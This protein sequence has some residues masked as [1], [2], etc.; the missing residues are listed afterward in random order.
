VGSLIFCLPPTVAVVLVS[1][2]VGGVVGVSIGIYIE[3]PFVWGGRDVWGTILSR[4]R[5]QAGIAST[6]LGRVSIAAT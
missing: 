5:Y 4:C 1:G 2:G 6:I 3:I